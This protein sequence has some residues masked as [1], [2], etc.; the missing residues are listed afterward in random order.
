MKNFCFLIAVVII[1]A[2]AYEIGAK[3][4]RTQCNSPKAVKNASYKFTVKPQQIKR[5]RT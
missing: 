3:T 4:E 1:A 2:W 5:I